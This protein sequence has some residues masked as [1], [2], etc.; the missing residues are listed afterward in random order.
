MNVE[1]APQFD[2]GRSMFDVGSSSFSFSFPR[3][4]VVT[5]TSMEFGMRD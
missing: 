2:V 5:H 4:S 1:G 3:S